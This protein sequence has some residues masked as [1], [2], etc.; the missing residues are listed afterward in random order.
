MDKQASKQNT[1]ADSKG[2]LRTRG[3]EHE[4]AEVTI[5]RAPRIT[6]IFFP[7]SLLFAAA[8]YTRTCALLGARGFYVTPIPGER[9]VAG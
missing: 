3:R 7:L 1:H 8:T 4:L 6:E 9:E 2:A 5:F